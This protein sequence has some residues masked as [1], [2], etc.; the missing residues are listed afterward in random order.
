M[1]TGEDR[2]IVPRW[3]VRSDHYTRITALP[4]VLGR[5]FSGVVSAVYFA[6]SY[7]YCTN[8]STAP[9][10]PCRLGFVDSMT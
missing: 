8:D 2:R 6:S 10:K 5:D 9:S 3:K 7:R 4:H 1:E